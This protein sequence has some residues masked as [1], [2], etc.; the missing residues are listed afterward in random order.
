MSRDSSWRDQLLPQP[1]SCTFS[2]RCSVSCSDDETRS[3]KTLRIDVDIELDRAVLLRRRRQPLT[4]IGREIEIAR[5]FDQQ[6][7]TMP[8]AHQSER[9]FGGA[10]DAHLIVGWRGAGE[11]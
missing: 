6:A 3:Q 11:S 10:E 4:Q 2:L 8:A 7:E 9:R 5:R 1:F